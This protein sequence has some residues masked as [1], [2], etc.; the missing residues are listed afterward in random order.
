[1]HDRSLRESGL[2]VILLASQLSLQLGEGSLLLPSLSHGDRSASR[3]AW[4]CFC[5]AT[6][7]PSGARSCGGARDCSCTTTSHRTCSCRCSHRNLLDNN[8][9]RELNAACVSCETRGTS[10]GMVRVDNAEGCQAFA[11][12]LW[13]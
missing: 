5:K 12:L 10:C 9:E 4:C 1:M 6:N 2:Q 11:S 7:K 8:N 3:L 13:G